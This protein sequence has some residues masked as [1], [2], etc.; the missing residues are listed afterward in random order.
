V[1]VLVADDHPVFRE[2][3]VRALQANPD[4]ELV[5]E[6]GD[7]RAALA[8][9][10]ASEPDVALLDYKLPELDGIAVLRAVVRDGLATRVLILSAHD[11]SSVVYEALQA[12]ASG[13][14]P[15]EASREQIVDAVFAVARGESV[16]PSGL[17]AGLVGEI[18][19]RSSSDAP[20]LTE[21]ERQILRLMADG[22][23]FPEIATTLFLGV[24]TVKTHAQHLYEKL[25]VSD[26]AAAVAVAIRKHLIE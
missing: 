5:A 26:R 6:V 20:A 23:S 16:L 21:R 15:K 2:G 14:L 12:G 7:G 19:L 17:A 22:K 18:R 8:G 10:I 25:G 1:R 24:T 9:I 13:F 11:D 4:A 3:I